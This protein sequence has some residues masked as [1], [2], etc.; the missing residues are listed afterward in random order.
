MSWVKLTLIDDRTYFEPGAN[1]QGQVA[2]SFD[3][4]PDRLELRLFWY[5]EGRGTQDVAIVDLKALEEPGMN[6]SRNFTF[7]LPE[8]PYSFSGKLISLKWALEAI[9]EPESLVERVELLM[10][11]R[12]V[13]VSPGDGF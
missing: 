6:G 4:E 9:A 7:R 5:T 12:P 2:W 11:P 13:E 1:L 10:G 8:A 3:S